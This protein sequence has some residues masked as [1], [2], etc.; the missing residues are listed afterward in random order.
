MRPAFHEDGFVVVPRLLVPAEVEEWI[1]CLENHSGL[2]RRDFLRAQALGQRRRGLLG[3]WT[4]PDGVSRSRDFWPLIFHDRLLSAARELLG[5]H[6]RFLQHTDLH[7]GFSALGWHRDNVD[8]SFGTGADWDESREP[9]LILRAGV[10]LQSY[11]E[12]R[13]R[14]GVV[15]GTHR[16]PARSLTAE[17][18]R[19]E[20]AT[21]WWGQARRAFSAD[22][23]AAREAR[24]LEVESG[25]CVLFDPRLLHSGTPIDGPTYSFFLSYGVPNGHFQRHR[26]YYRRR[27]PELGYRDLAPELVE[28]L[29]AASLHAPDPPAAQTPLAGLKPSW[30]ETSLA[31]SVRYLKHRRA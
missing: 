8:R 9:Y 5:P 4:L 2:R 25:D 24:W 1:V 15:P 19:L 18:Q 14:L 10:Y 21:G 27:R 13:F 11:G 12:S 29:R 20:S 16:P 6:V 7:V 17:R 23:P 28:R 31:R 26:A 30:L 3:A 22:D